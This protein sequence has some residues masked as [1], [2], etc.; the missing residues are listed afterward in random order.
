LTDAATEGHGYGD[1]GEKTAMGSLEELAKNWEGFAQTD[2]LW[3]ICTDPQKRGNKWDEEE[4]FETG[5]KEI[6]KVLSYV[7]SLGLHLDLTAPALDFGCGVG[8]LTRALTQ[9]FTECWGVDISP[10]MI[11][12]AKDFH[13]RN[14]RCHFCI[15]Q[16][17][18]LQ[19]FSD[20]YFGFVYTSIVLQHIARR[21]AESYIKE[22]IRVLKPGGIFIFQIVDRYPCGI[23][24]ALRARARVRSRLKA[25]LK[26]DETSF[27]ME[28]HSIKEELI[29]ELLSG[30]NVQIA[31]VRL[32]N[33]LEPSFNGEL[34]YLDQELQ[35]NWYISKQY[36]VMKNE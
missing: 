15:N 16:T 23:M 22:L 7:Q 19:K 24:R 10:T 25:L 26:R 11:E 30:G 8:R 32:T 17:A 4:F 28:M 1:R 36:C 12:L 18:N 9:H 34:R 5:R 3:S 35:D 27:H 21:Y 31:D 6:D 33:S 2:P 14:P 13:K 20:A 29:R